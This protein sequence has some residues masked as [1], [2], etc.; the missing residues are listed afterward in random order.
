MYFEHFFAVAPIKALCS[1]RHKDW[2]AKFEPFGL[3]CTELTGDTD[4][5]DFH[6][7]QYAHIVLTTPVCNYVSIL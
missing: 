3:T 7:L 6:V 5:D 4:L 2:S 1:E